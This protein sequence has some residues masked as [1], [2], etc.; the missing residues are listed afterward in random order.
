MNT[1]KHQGT[2]QHECVS[3]LVGFREE[4]RPGNKAMSYDVPPGSAQGELEYKCRG[5]RV[6][7][8]ESWD[9]REYKWRGR[10][11]Q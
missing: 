1:E 7:H 11:V 3:K 6:Q 10:R 9:V 8:R 2:E 5:R 4:G